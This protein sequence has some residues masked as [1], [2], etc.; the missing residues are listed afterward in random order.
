MQ[1]FLS[2]FDSCEL[3]HFEYELE[4]SFGLFFD[5]FEEVGSGIVIF[6]GTSEECVGAGLD[7]G[8]GGFEF[9][10]D[11]ADEIAAHGFESADIGDIADNDNSA[12]VWSFLDG[13]YDED[14]VCVVAWGAVFEGVHGAILE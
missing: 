11:T 3:E 13:D 9:V 4:E 1:D 8:E 14:V 12:R 5:L 7:D 10:R 6:E 2:G